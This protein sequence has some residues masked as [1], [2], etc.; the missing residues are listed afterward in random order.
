MDQLRDYQLLCRVAPPHLKPVRPNESPNN[1]RVE[2]N[3]DRLDLY[4]N[5]KTGGY[6]LYPVK[7][8]VE[9]GKE[10]TKQITVV[11]F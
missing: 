5:A 11:Y 2:Y 7:N 1:V 10:Q 8:A 9:G 3:L 4:Y 6:E